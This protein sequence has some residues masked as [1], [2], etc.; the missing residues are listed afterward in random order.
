MNLILQD[1]DGNQWEALSRESS[2]G[3][4]QMAGFAFRKDPCCECVWEGLEREKADLGA[5]LYFLGLQ[6][7]KLITPSG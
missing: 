5:L 7:P 2:E 1:G 4:K 3:S 6:W